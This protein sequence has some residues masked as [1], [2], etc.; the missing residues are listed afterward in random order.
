MYYVK[1]VD[2]PKECITNSTSEF[3]DSW[4]CTGLSDFGT[5][6]TQKVQFIAKSK[7]GK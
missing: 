6:I 2:V 4:W 7:Y 1:E 5:G 3:K